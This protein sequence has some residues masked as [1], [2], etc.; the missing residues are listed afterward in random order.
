MGS[1]RSG[2]VSRVNDAKA[3]SNFTAAVVSTPAVLGDGF[4]RRNLSPVK[5]LIQRGLAPHHRKILCSWNEDAFAHP[6]R[7]VLQR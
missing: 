3:C 5:G 1:T 6:S 7:F 2:L 4:V